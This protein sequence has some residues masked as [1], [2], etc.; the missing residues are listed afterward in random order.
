MDYERK[1][2]GVAKAGLATGITG[3]ALATLDI[4]KDHWGCKDGRR[5]GY[6]Y[7]GAYGAPYGA[8]YG[9]PYP[10]PAPAPGCGCYV[11][12]KEMCLIRENAALGDVNAKQ[13]SEL[14]TNHVVNCVEEKLEKQINCVEEKLEGAIYA[15]GN[16]VGKLEGG[17][18]LEC[19]RRECGDQNI[20]TWA[21]CEFIHSEKDIMNS[22]KIDWHGCEPIL[23][24]RERERFD[25]DDRR[26]DRD[27][28]HERDCGCGCG[29]QR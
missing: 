11:T 29:F 10:A 7:P 8:P 12:E 1:S 19:E 23:R 18:A 17:L 28:D 6:G 24:N 21:N 16:R 25:R 5:D 9:V 27:C 14:Y 20:I 4:I 3:T 22:K 26:G 13:A 15:L 2:S